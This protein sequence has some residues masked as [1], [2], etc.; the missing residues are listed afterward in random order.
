LPFEQRDS[1]ICLY[2]IL[3]F[4][5]DV[6]EKIKDY[7]CFFYLHNM[8]LLVGIRVGNDPI[9]VFSLKIL[10]LDKCELKLFWS[11]PAVTNEEYA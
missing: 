10:S 9:Y 7:T 6:I 11:E 8:S 1:F 3:V 4:C 2:L 5:F